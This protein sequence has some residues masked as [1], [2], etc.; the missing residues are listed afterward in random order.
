MSKAKKQG[1]TLVEVLIVVVIMAI[2]AATIIPQF[3]DSTKDAK[4]NTSKFNLH[5][6]R[7]Q[8]ELYKSQHD[9]KVPAALSDLTVKT[10]TAGTIGTTTAFPY[11]PYLSTLPA[12]PFTGSNTVAVAATNPPTAATGST[13]AGWLYH[14]A[15][16]SVYIDNTDLLTQ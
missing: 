13:T 8:I 12:N 4:N 14:A 3:S 11:G 5:T 1:F 15:S 10:N 7:S 9:G 2:L 16:G 6:I